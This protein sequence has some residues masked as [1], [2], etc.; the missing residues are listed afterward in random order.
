VYG[1]LLLAADDGSHGHEVWKSDGSE[2]GTTLVQD[3]M[4]GV[5]SSNP[6]EF[7]VVFDKVF[8]VATDDRAGTEL[9]MAPLRALDIAQPIYY[10]PYVARP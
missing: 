7:T 5:A 2:S 1:T 10:L 9:W 8:F 6:Y 4:P 3:I